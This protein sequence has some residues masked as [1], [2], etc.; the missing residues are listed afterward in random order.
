M[1]LI[2]KQTL[3]IKTMDKSDSYT[4]KVNGLNNVLVAPLNYVVYTE[5]FF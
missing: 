4:E 3:Y 5:G 2:N 1:N